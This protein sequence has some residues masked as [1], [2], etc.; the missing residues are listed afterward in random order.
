MPDIS[1]MLGMGDDPCKA[2]TVEHLIGAPL[3]S[4]AELAQIEGPK[5]IRVIRPGDAVTMDHMPVRLNI[6]VDEDDIVRRLRCG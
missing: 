2:G 6:E 3:P 4:E 5:R 1:S